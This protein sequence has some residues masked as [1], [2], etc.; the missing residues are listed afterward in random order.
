MAHRNVNL[1]P[2]VED[3]RKAADTVIKDTRDLKETPERLVAVNAVRNA[4]DGIRIHHGRANREAF[5]AEANALIIARQ[6]VT[7]GQKVAS[8]DIVL[9]QLKRSRDWDGF[10]QEPVKRPAQTGFFQTL[11]GLV[12]RSEPQ[13]A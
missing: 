4:M 7:E 12:R 3:Y 6:D 8:D 2:T 9:A 10:Y 1:H 13:P 11:V 5:I